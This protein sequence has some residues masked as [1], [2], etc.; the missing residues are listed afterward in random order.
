MTTKSLL[1]LALT[2]AGMSL[3]LAQTSQNIVGYVN[4]TCPVGLSMIANQLDNG[5]G[6]TV[7]DLIK[8][9]PDGT[10]LYK[11]AGGKF[12]LNTYV[13]PAWDIPTMTLA[14][15]EGAFV[16]NVDTKAFTIT[17][18][19]DVKLGASSVALPKGLSIISSVIPQDIA[20]KDINGLGFGATDGD[21]I[22]TF[23]A[24]KFALNTYVDPAWDA[25]AAVIAVGT[26]FFFQNAGD[27]AKTWNRTF[28]VN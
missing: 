3:A 8:G 9:V 27:A 18:V 13:D 23:A 12:T 24:G 26:A 20:A 4:V 10:T 22:Y 21:T 19:G 17:F 16:A 15:G 6:N 7:A 5:K 2:G 1:A 28:T 25:P 11:F 14:P